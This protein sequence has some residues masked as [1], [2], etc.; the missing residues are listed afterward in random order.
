MKA[1]RLSA[2]MSLYEGFGLPPLEAMSAGTPVIAPDA[3]SI[4]E[5]AGGNGLLVDPTRVRHIAEGVVR[6]MRDDAL[7][8]ELQARGRTRARLCS[9]ERT[10]GLTIAAY[11]RAANSRFNRDEDRLPRAHS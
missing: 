3:S 8:K 10:A 7:A 1:A 9:W 11:Q 2:Y 6:P 4:R 5:V